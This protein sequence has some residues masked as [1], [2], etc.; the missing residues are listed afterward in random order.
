MDNCQ[1]NEVHAQPVMQAMDCETHLL[2]LP[3]DILG[4]LYAKFGG[5]TKSKAALRHSCTALYKCANILTLAILVLSSASNS[6]TSANLMFS[7]HTS[8]SGLRL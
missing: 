5:D 4:K 8:F 6:C 3:D 7:C 1:G 2:D